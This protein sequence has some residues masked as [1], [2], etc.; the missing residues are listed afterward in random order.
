MD[1]GPLPQ[2]E[3]VGGVTRGRLLRRL[4]VGCGALSLGRAA[5]ALAPAKA[6]AALTAGDRTI[7]E[8]A[9]MLEHLQA[10]FYDQALRAGKLTGEPRQFAE[11]V[12]GQEHAHLSYLQAE[13]GSGAGN[14]PTYRFGDAVRANQT[15]VAAAVTLEELGLAAY[16]GQAENLSPS[17]LGAVARVIS[18][19]A[20]HVA[21]VRG[22][23]GRR[24]APA[25]A[26]I[27]ISATAAMKAIRP[28]MA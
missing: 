7:L 24:P 15:F 2:L 6:T 16:N 13:L 27:P 22:L 14:A 1:Q 21:W 9:L 12:G 17:A 3:K 20:R 25:A 4:A 28:Y 10:G 8:F 5:A 19:E 26:D 11:I 23:A 18:V